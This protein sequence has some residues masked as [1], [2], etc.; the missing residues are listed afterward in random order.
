MYNDSFFL[1]IFCILYISFILEDV[2]I[3]TGRKT[4]E[5]HCM[6][7]I[8]KTYIH[9]YLSMETF[10][11]H[12]SLFFKCRFT[13]HSARVGE[14]M[15]CAIRMFRDKGRTSN[16][17]CAIEYYKLKSSHFQTIIHPWIVYFNR[18]LPNSSGRMHVHFSFCILQVWTT[19]L[20]LS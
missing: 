4:E 20:W 13:G 5:N 15:F 18:S 17:L 16:Y 3:T 1:D 2:Y 19:T 9:I 7:V 6:G 11:D 14:S 12:G 8:V 10:K